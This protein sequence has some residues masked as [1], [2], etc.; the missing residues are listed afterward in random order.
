MSKFWAEARRLGGA[1]ANGREAAGSS[2]SSS[3]RQ[4]RGGTTVESL[5][6]RDNRDFLVEAEAVVYK[7]PTPFPAVTA[8]NPDLQGNKQLGSGETPTSCTFPG[9]VVWCSGQSSTAADKA[10][11]DKQHACTKKEYYE[12]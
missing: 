8:L 12:L 9:H 3:G 7:R 5:L 1:G 4:G 2:S 6:S 11:V 10:P